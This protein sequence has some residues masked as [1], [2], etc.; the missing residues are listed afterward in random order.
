M[1]SLRETSRQTPG[2]R[3]FHPGTELLP[4]AVRNRMQYSL[5][6]TE[7]LVLSAK[8]SITKGFYCIFNSL[9]FSFKNK[10]LTLTT[11]MQVQSRWM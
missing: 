7:R 9:S 10:G 8:I 3:L 1:A 11:P 5:L 6:L 2:V 4:T